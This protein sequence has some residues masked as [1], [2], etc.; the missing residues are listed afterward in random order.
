MSTHTEEVAEFFKEIDVD[1]S[2]KLEINELRRLFGDN[3]EAVAAELDVSM[4]N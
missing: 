2:G 4:A 1:G 3:S